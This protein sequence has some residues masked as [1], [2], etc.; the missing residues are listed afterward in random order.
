MADESIRQEFFHLRKVALV[1]AFLEKAANGGLEVPF[2]HHSLASAPSRVH[3]V[4]I[5]SASSLIG[6]AYD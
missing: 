3:C 2:R 1:P 4:R 6:Q 5:G